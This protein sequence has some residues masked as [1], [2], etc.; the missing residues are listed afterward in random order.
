MQAIAESAIILLL[1]VFS[2][3]FSGSE[4]SLLS[5]SEHERVKLSRGRD[6]K[7]MLL[8]HYLKFP[9]KALITILIGNMVVN[10]AASIL[11]EQVS[12]LVFNRNQLFFS[13]FIMTFL[14]LLAGEVIPKNVA[15]SHP[16]LFSKHFIGIVNITNR[17]FAPLVAGISRIVRSGERRATLLTKQELTSAVE[18]GSEAGLD[19]TSINLLKN[20]IHLIDLPILDLMIPRSDIKGIDINE[21][22]VNIEKFIQET[23][24]S[25]VLFY[26]EHVD[27]VV[28]YV[29]K[30]KLLNARKKDLENILIKPLYIP[31]SKHIFTLLREFK[32]S[33]KYMAIVLDEYGGTTGLVTVKDILDSIFIRQV[34]LRKYFQRTSETTWLVRGNTPIPDVNELLHLDVPTEQYT[35]GGFASNVIGDIPEV[36]TV[37]PLDDRYNAKVMKRGEKQ[38]ELMEIRRVDS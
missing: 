10:S 33:G 16:V 38:I 35:I 24:F 22:W 1:L 6:R 34:L 5:I 3:I 23:S 31:E 4:V 8:L 9:Q 21:S 20:L 2:Y 37:V 30:N 12:L 7:N 25:T 36:G 29:K 27:D 28:G 11:G 13:V 14:L 18:T 19:R 26:D 32:Q 15:A 17:M